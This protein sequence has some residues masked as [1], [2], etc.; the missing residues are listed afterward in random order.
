MRDFLA[1][2]GLELPVVQAGMGGG[3]AGGELAGTVSAAGALGTVGIMAP[4]AFA[5]ALRRADERAAGR[6]V[7][8][9]LLVPFVRSAHIDACVEHDVALVVFHGGFPSRWVARLREARVPVFVTVATAEEAH[10]ALTGGADGL[11]VQGVEA[12]G[13]LVGKEPLSVALPRV[14]EAV[15]HAVPVFAAG[16]VADSSDVRRLLEQGATAAVAGTRFL[17]TEESQAHPAY[18]QRVLEADRTLVTLLFGIGWPMRHRVVP[19]AA[20]E[21]WCASAELAPDWLRRV[22]R[23]SAPLGRTLPLGAMARVAPLQRVGVPFFSPGLPLE[24][25]SATS[26]DTLAL[27]AGETMHR[28]TSVVTAAEAVG[29][30]AP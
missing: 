9:N 10:R 11:V 28:I 4:R 30:L 26:V 15:S 24:G 17:L 18:K 22:G 2:I 23:V 5:Q 13:H 7:A 21:R 25:M 29:Q 19:N 14:L 3:V 16:G 12:G 8:A 6:P 1:Q 20:T 27:Y